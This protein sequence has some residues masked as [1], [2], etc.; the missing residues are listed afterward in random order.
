MARLVICDDET[1]IT[2]ILS[3]F[4]REKGH[5][6]FGT[7]HA[8]A[9]AAHALER[10][11]DLVITDIAMQGLSGFDLLKRIKASGSDIPVIIT[12]GNPSHHSAVQALREGAFD[13]VVKP[14]HLEEILERAE[15]AFA[16]RRIREENV[17]YSK[18]VSL[19]SISRLLAEAA[20]FRALSAKVVQMGAKLI[21]GDAGW[22][23]TAPVA[24][25]DPASTAAISPEPGN[26]DLNSLL[27]RV[28]RETLDKGDVL[29]T[30]PSSDSAGQDA[31]FLSLPVVVGSAIHG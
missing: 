9:A 20:D 11:V 30:N 23:W 18:L 25:S 14:F 24:A 31:Q 6:V 1:H 5:E 10:S 28:A 17:L 13:Y 22:Y 7:V 19:H 3:R 16:M 29:V 4:F 21:R 8:E 26:P 15:R 12:T 27:L 2:D